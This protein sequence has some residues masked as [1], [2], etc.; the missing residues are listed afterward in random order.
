MKFERKR[1]RL[2]FLKL[3]H[4][5]KIVR[6]LCQF[7]WCCLG[8]VT[9]YYVGQ[10]HRNRRQIHISSHLNIWDYIDQNKIFLQ[11]QHLLSRLRNKFLLKLK[12]FFRLINMIFTS[13]LFAALKYPCHTPVYFE[14]NDK[15]TLKFFY[16]KH[17]IYIINTYFVVQHSHLAIKWTFFLFQKF[18]GRHQLSFTLLN[19]LFYN[20]EIY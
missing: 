12:F 1:E 14:N 13:C 11:L 4:F 18:P 7:S 19:Q 8:V 5:L 9:S 17:F 2:K 15:I 3:Y 10:R 20:L 16:E 6:S